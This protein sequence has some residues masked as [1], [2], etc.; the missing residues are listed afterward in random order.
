MFENMLRQQLEQDG[1]IT[2]ARYMELALYH[3]VHGY[4]RTGRD[5]F[6]TRGDF[7]TAEQLQPCF[8]EL[9]SSFISNVE[10]QEARDA[11]SVLELGAGRGELRAPLSR[12][13]YRG[14]DWQGD[15]L[16]ASVTG[17]VLANEFF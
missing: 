5:V 3:P 12:W 10:E 2:F 17:V 9:L 14:C 11:F 1:P 4:Y 7:Y 16:P 6:G 8:G 13:R 15:P